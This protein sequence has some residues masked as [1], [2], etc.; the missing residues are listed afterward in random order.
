MGR[1]SG[2][3]CNGMRH[4]VKILT[5]WRLPVIP[6]ARIIVAQSNVHR[7]LGKRMLQFQCNKT[8]RLHRKINGGSIAPVWVHAMKP[9]TELV[10]GQITTE[11]HKKGRWLPLSCGGQARL[12]QCPIRIDTGGIA[13]ALHFGELLCLTGCRRSIQNRYPTTHRRS[14]QLL[15]LARIVKRIK[16]DIA[17]HH[18]WAR[19]RNI[20]SRMHGPLSSNGNRCSR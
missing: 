3:R 13:C 18:N 4:T 15:E 1:R 14:L 8:C 7:R 2:L 5:S 16:V 17:Q 12:Q 20:C 9:A 6:A 11:R 19:G 10:H